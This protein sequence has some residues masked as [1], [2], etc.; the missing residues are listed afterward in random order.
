MN[1]AN[2]II[3]MTPLQALIARHLIRRRLGETFD[4][5]MLCYR[6]ADNAKFHHYFQ[7]AAALFFLT[8]AKIS[9]WKGRAD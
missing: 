8:H 6:E 3:C 2:L 9:D 7:A 4:L 1:P 5:L